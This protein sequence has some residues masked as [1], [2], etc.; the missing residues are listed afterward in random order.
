MVVR[1]LAKA[2]LST[3]IVSEWERELV[4]LIQLE[5]NY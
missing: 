2:G 5:N 4:L 1:L 3:Y